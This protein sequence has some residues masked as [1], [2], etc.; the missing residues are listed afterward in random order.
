M[1]TKLILSTAILAVI[2]T[3]AYSQVS[4]PSIETSF[5]NYI[6]ANSGSVNN[7]GILPNFVIKENT[8]GN[9]Y[10]YENWVDGFVVGTDGNTY[11]SSRYKYNY[12]KISRKLFM[13]YD[14]TTVIELSSGDIAG[15]TLKNPQGDQVFE[16]LKNSTDLNFY[17]AVYKEEKGYSLYKLLTTKYN[18]ADYQTNG[19]I[20]SG[21]KYDEYV[22]TEEYFILSPKQ[23]ITK[24]V[25][26]K[27]S[28]EKA[29]ENESAKVQAFFGQHKGDVLDQ[30][31]VKQLL[32][33][34][35][36]VKS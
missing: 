7:G 12:D 9:R 6:R 4:G 8:R 3:F 30:E 23:E 28:I 11:N 18:K 15:F 21:K 17:Q 35:N 31:Y 22:D 13:L 2:S 33:Y 29:L 32:Q 25:F 14:T 10:L 27:K 34:I 5:E 36:S 26:K 16:R 20:E 24:I 19:I 1:K